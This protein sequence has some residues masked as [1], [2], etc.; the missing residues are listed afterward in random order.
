MAN[1]SP[2][3]HCTARRDDGSFCDRHTVP[4]APFPICSH[5]LADIARFLNSVAPDA[6]E[7]LILANRA[8]D[9]SLFR[10]PSARREQFRAVVYYVRV[11]AVVKIGYTGRI[12]ERMQGYPPHAVLL[13]T[14]PGGLALEAQRHREY[15]ASLAAGR[16]WFHPSAALI[17][18][19][20]SLREQPLTA[21][22]LAA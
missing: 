1:A 8:F 12:G 6:I 7:A 19:I 3:Q 18:H 10:D 21:A 5:H 9:G 11:G 22:E 4:G 16:E 2:I 20:N 15:R 17:E 14:E 13:A